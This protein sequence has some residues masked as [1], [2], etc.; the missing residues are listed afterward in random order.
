MGRRDG[1]DTFEIDAPHFTPLLGG[2]RWPSKVF[3]PS[4]H[5]F[6]ADIAKV[7]GAIRP[8]VLHV[9][10][11]MGIPPELIPIAKGMGTKIVFTTHD[12]YGICPKANLID[13]SGRVCGGPDVERCRSCNRDA[14]SYTKSFLHS[15]KVFHIMKPLLRR[16]VRTRSVATVAQ[17]SEKSPRQGTLEE[18]GA[19]IRFHQDLFEFVDRFHF[20]SSISESV[21]RRHVPGIAGSILHVTHAGI[22]DHRD[23]PYKTHVPSRLGFIGDSTPYKGFP[24]L[25]AISSRIRNRGIKDW[26]LHVFGPGHDQDTHQDGIVVHGAFSSNDAASIFHS[27]DALIV[28]SIWSETFGFVVLEAISHG[29]P[30]VTMCNVGAKDLIA[31]TPGLLARSEVDLETI[32]ERILTN[33]QELV[34]A[35]AC[36]RQV[37]LP[38][39][40]AE[41]AME[42][43]KI[44][45]A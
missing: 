22:R 15:Q 18:Y 4:G 11:L 20:N 45:G 21:Y 36:I 41:H 40:M 31:S 10:T 8:D 27:L 35:A 25:R 3:R 24:L 33:P 39:G 44:Y 2:I 16:F 26:D 6:Q 17:S 7:L 13:R 43:R 38:Q 5:R 28:P 32:I 14:Q 29:I 42:I 23:T 19:L 34:D 37:A 12:Y 1:I 30:V 9:H